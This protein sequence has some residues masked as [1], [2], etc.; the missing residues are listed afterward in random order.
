MTLFSTFHKLSTSTSLGKP[1]LFTALQFS[2]FTLR[3]FAC[4][5]PDNPN[6]AF[7]RLPLLFCIF[8]SKIGLVSVEYRRILL[9]SMTITY[10]VKLNQPFYI[11]TSTNEASV[12]FAIWNTCICFLFTFYLYVQSKA[13]ASL[14]RAKHAYR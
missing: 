14:P 3:F 10:T 4:L 1:L 9:F 8:T 12:Q 5:P 7:K 11:S 2:L 13:A 6:L